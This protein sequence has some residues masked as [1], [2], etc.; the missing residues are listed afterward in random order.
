M[1]YLNFLGRHFYMNQYL[2]DEE[3]T[4]LVIS[5][6]EKS[7]DFNLIDNIEVGKILSSKA[8]KIDKD[9]INEELKSSSVWDNETWDI[10]NKIKKLIKEVD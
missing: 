8:V 1:R 7:R 10:F 4:D 3:I 5:F 6:Y 9:W 2:V